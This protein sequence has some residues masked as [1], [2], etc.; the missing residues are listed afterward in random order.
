[1]TNSDSDAIA[2]ARAAVRALVE[3]SRTDPEFRRQVQA[4]PGAALTA[5][6]VPTE[7][8]G[9]D[10][11]PTGWSAD[12]ACAMTCLN[13]DLDEEEVGGAADGCGPGMVGALL[14]QMPSL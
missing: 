14:S 13:T 12:R 5:A 1:M 3:R 8:H 7:L 6:G 9:T 11:G 2:Q 10:P 4:D